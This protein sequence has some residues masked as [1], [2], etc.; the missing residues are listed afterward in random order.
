MNIF[1]EVSETT[2]ET[3]NEFCTRNVKNKYR[4]GYSQFLAELI[5]YNIIDI[6]IFIKTVN[7]IISQIEYNRTNTESVKLN[8][9]YSD[10]LMK[11]TKAI[12]TGTDKN[13]TQINTIFKTDIL[14]RIQ[15]L[16]LRNGDNLGMSN[17][18]RFTMLN[19]YEGF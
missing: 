10:C 19:I 16:T 7:K 17:K 11:I 15:P 13:I 3:Y 6:D 12:K 14:H 4:R 2:E 1:D 8:E 18:A 5:K 9:E